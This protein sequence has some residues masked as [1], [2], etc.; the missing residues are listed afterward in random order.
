M[1][2]GRRLGAVEVM[3]QFFYLLPFALVGITVLLLRTDYA[4]LDQHVSSLV[5][6]FVAMFLLLSQPFNI[7]IR[8]GRSED[9]L[10]IPTSFAPLV[11][12]SALFISGA[13]GLWALVFAAAAAAL[14]QSR[15]LASYGQNP[16]WRPL[17]FFVAQIG[18][19]LFPTLIAADLYLALGGA[20]PV[21]G[22]TLGDWIPALGA[23]IFGALLSG[24]LLLPVAIQM[25]SL[26]ATR[27]RPVNLARFYAGAVAL[28]LL[29]SP[30]AIII[31]LLNAERQTL[32][33]V[34]ILI[35]I[36]L[37]NR[38][39][40]HMSKAEARSREQARELNQLE[41]LAQHIIEA[42]PDGSTLPELLAAALPALFP[43]ERLTIHLF[44]PPENGAWTSF[45]V[46]QPPT[47]PSVA[48][49]EDWS[50]LRQAPGNRLLLPEVTLPGKRRSFGDALVVK[51][52]VEGTQED[53]AFECAGGIYLL[54]HKSAGASIDFLASVE[55]LASQI[56]TALTRARTYA[57]LLAF[58]KAQQELQFAGK[59]QASFLPS[60]I[61]QASNWQ[62]SATL[63]SARQTSGDFYDFI[64]F[65]DGLIGLVV[66][67][68]SDKGTGAALYMALSRTLLR[69]Y[70]M[71]SGLH[72][73]VALARA[74]D[75]IRQDAASDQFVTLIYGVLDPATGLLTYANAGHNPGYLLRVEN[76]QVDKL[77][78]TGIPL[79][80]F[81]GMAWER[82]QIQIQP[83]DLLLLYTDGVPEAQNLAH[84]EFG[85]DRFVALGQ[86]K[87]GLP[88]A[89]IQDTV[90]AAIDEFAGDAPQFDDITLMVITREA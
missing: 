74:N 73:E 52:L 33:L 31:A 14:W 28:P 88:A 37:V 34:F 75:R 1:D 24:V 3:V 12:W 10:N 58:H 76:G 63:I 82:A 21:T 7:R 67:D 23:I 2:E 89:E 64:P 72:P 55:S 8:L 42:P 27:N 16:L 43:A 30:F 19:Y 17:S 48:T 53:E 40:H 35:G 49:A 13:A 38:L 71:E 59:I 86:E 62:I 39:A 47:E 57:E 65:E 11:M 20:F 84:E 18:V 51:I 41:R 70:A 45:D 29:M 79:G 81:E 44:D 25:N 36:Y 68:V 50:K 6:L 26:S 90:I 78:R 46:N 83:G 4:R 87:Q 15:Q 61:P 22:Y 60:S 80:M 5:V 66:A 56:G 32:V 54:R 85:D 77:I 69:T 9:E